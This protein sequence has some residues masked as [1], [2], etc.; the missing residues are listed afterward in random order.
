[1]S[2]RDGEFLFWNNRTASASTYMPTRAQLGDRMFDR[3]LSQP[4]CSEGDQN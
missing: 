4:C 3:L 1:L 2:R